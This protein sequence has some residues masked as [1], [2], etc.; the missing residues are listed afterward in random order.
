MLDV[1]RNLGE[2]L[3]NYKYDGIIN[4]IIYIYIYIYV[5]PSALPLFGIFG[6]SILYSLRFIDFQHLVHRAGYYVE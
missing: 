4:R 2:L 6:F 1:Q 5:H 3:V